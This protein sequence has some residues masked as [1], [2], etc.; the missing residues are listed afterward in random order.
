M[1]AKMVH[2]CVHVLD[3]DAS[4]EFYHK[5]LGLKEIKRHS[6]EDGS[7]A[8]VFLAN[9]TTDFELELTWNKGRVEPY[10]NGGG[11]THLAFTVPDFEAAR[12]LHQE[13][14]CIVHENLEM[15]I[16]FITDPDGT[17]LEILSEA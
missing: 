11:D 17:W 16:Y 7:W 13:M 12:I 3:L 10:D 1:E 14:D 4:L 9:D 5:A 6:P 2:Y 8:L 15:G